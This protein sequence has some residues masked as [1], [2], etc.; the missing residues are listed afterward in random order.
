MD[1]SIHLPWDMITAVCGQ[2]NTQPQISTS[3][4]NRDLIIFFVSCLHT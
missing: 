1:Y 4:G 2:L 3:L